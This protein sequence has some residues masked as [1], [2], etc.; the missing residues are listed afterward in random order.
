[1]KIRL[2]ILDK[3]K[4]FLSRLAQTC[5][6]K[7][8]EKLEIYTFTEQKMALDTLEKNVIDVFL[9]SDEFD[10]EPSALPSRCGFAYLVESSAIDTIRDQKVVSKYQRIELLYRNV[11]EIYSEN[12][13]SS[14]RL[15]LA[16]ETKGS[17][18]QFFSAS[19][20][21][22]C[23]TMAAACATYFSRAGSKVLFFSLEEFMSTDAFF[24][25]EGSATFS[26]IVFALK[27]KRG[28]AM[29]KIESSIKRDQSGVF[30]I[31][32][33]VTPLE[34]RELTVDDVK[35]LLSTI[36]MSGDYD[37]IIIDVGSLLSDISFEA[38]K[39]ADLMVLV[40]DGSEISNMK[41][42][43]AI[44]AL[45]IL[46]R[47]GDVSYLNRFALA[48]NKFSNKTGRTLDAVGI[49]SLSGAPKI[50]RATP[51]EIVQQLQKY[52]IFDEL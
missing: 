48:Y 10:I 30:F 21:V 18:I 49:R 50:E 44:G 5:A 3:D 17:V 31:S 28:N 47:Q 46:E 38:I 35:S 52:S 43:Q 45:E 34:L 19:G 2:A 23:S 20:G 12:I 1:M 40:S 37:H 22:G 6:S 42:T 7:Y 39:Q 8:P 15:K 32:G 24:A 16:G 14:V 11:L 41:T 36:L 26:D 29:L 33:S 51:R 25:G 27:S 4:T 9:S 13:P